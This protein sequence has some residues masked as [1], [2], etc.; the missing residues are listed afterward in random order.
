[1]SDHS[2]TVQ[3][4]IRLGY[5][6][7]ALAAGWTFLVAVSLF[8]GISQN[9]QTTRELATKEARTHFAKDQAF[10]FW[11]SSHGGVFVPANERTPPNRYLAHVPERDITTPSGKKLTLMNP[12]YMIR[13]LHEEFADLYG[14]QGKITSLKPLNQKNAPDKWEESALK[15]F[16]DGMDEQFEFADI[17]GKPYLRLMKVMRVKKGCLKCHGFQGYKVGDVR[18][19]VGVSVPMSDYLTKERR[20]MIL[21][22]LTHGMLWLFGI[23]GIFFA[24]SNLRK[25]TDELIKTEED[26]KKTNRILRALSDCNQILVHAA[27]E[28]SLLEKICN[29]IVDVGGYRLAW[30]GFAENDETK[31]VRPVAQA[32]YEEGYLD[33]VK[34]TWADTERGRGPT[35][36]AVR[37]GKA[38]ICR[39]VMTDPR[40]AP[41]HDEAAKR[42]FNSV[43]GAPLIADGQTLGAIT[44]YSTEIDGFDAQEVKLMNE[45]A[46]DLAYGIV[47]LRNRS[48]RIRAEKELQKAYQGLESKVE[49]RTEELAQANIKLQEL[50]RMKSMFIASM[51]HELRTPLNSIIGFTGIL[52]Q[53]L[54]GGIND[55]QRKQLILVKNSAN[56]LLALINDIIDLSKIEAGKVELRIKEFDL[57]DLIRELE[58][59]FR[60]SVSEKG[61]KL[62]L[63]VP[64]RLIVK[65]D[66]RRTK[67]VLFNFVSNAVK[68]TDSGEIAIKTEKRDGCVE[69]SVRDTGIGIKKDHM[70]RL[71][72]AFSRIRNEGVPFREGTGLGL[73]LSKKIADLLHGEIRAESEIGKG[74]VFTF[75]LP[76]PMGGTGK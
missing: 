59:S 9:R 24:Y 44:I 47:S 67:Q 53:E 56:H 27:D 13:Q 16:E 18:G 64:D 66:E 54:P 1:M 6:M 17:R 51:S 71:F 41:W 31:T 8:W 58:E 28:T 26:L 22:T 11:A 76:L 55:E 30:V 20:G 70:E 65:S 32:G 49:E 60:V 5:Y 74:S 36:T 62:S 21:L 48:E 69:V 75:S 68:F 37:T 50:D 15:A 29:I 72:K 14:V 19:G 46:D 38:Y 73:Y 3:H 4:R 12:A 57:S 35:G 10:R 25:R 42:G 45:L 43:M 7:L 23:G 39:N 63:G 61:L 2:R 40:F 34:V 52:L 33:T